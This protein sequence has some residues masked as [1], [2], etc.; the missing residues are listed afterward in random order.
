MMITTEYEE[1][2][3]EKNFLLK[4]FNTRDIFNE[5]KIN[6]AYKIKY[7]GWRNGFNSEFP[8]IISVKEVINET[9][10]GK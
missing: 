5:L 9:K 3:N 2:L 8:N 1:F 6:E 7:Y 4:K 10:H